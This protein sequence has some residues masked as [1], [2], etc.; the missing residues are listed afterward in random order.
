MKL[1][2]REKG[3]EIDRASVISHTKRCDDRRYKNVKN[4]KNED[5]EVKGKGEYLKVLNRP[6]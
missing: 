5:W 4:V 1:R 2:E 3:E 6:K